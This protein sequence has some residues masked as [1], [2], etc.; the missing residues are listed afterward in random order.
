MDFYT[1]FPYFLTVSLIVLAI[2]RKTPVAKGRTGERRVS[3]QLRRCRGYVVISDIMLRRNDGG[4][5]QIDHVAVG[6][7]GVYVIE[8]KN[9]RAQVEGNRYDDTWYVGCNPVH[10]PIH[11]NYGHVCTLREL[12]GDDTVT[13]HSLVVFPDDNEVRVF[14]EEI[15]SVSEMKAEIICCHDNELTA[16]RIKDISARIKE[17]NISSRKERRA[18]VHRVRIESGR[19]GLYGLLHICPDCG[20][21]LSSFT[22]GGLKHLYCKSCG[23]KQHRR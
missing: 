13:F 14:A 20:K 22:R 7:A 23:Y 11:Q 6:P 3:R 2:W 9:Y 21:H 8:T 4:T 15:C 18:H 16:D 12:L 10:N 5:T 19:L 17:A 1:S